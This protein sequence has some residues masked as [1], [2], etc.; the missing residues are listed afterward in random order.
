[1]EGVNTKATAEKFIIEPEY[2]I[3]LAI[4]KQMPW[5][6]LVFMLTDLT[7][8]LDR[9]KHVIRV[10]VQELEK[11]VLNVKNDSNQDVINT[12]LTN[13]KQGNTQIQEDKAH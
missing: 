10:L 9:S 12:L 4:R 3:Q 11:W 2:L 13:E 5:N 6:T 7:T 1:M 8:S